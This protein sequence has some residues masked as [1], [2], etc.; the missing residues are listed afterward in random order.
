MLPEHS[1]NFSS[2]LGPDLGHHFD[3]G[4]GPAVYSPLSPS[5]GPGMWQPSVMKQDTTYLQ[6]TGPNTFMMDTMERSP[7][8]PGPGGYT[9]GGLGDVYLCGLIQ[10]NLQIDPCQEPAFGARVPVTRTAV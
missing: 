7:G 9:L 6:S 8:Q 1:F 3:P 10:F 2:D 5:P 4:Y